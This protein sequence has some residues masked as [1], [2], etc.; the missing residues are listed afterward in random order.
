M[1]Y[2][3]HKNN[4]TPAYKE[5][6]KKKFKI[7]ALQRLQNFP[8]NTTEKLLDT[9]LKENYK[10]S[11]LETC[12]LI[13]LKCRLDESKDTFII[14]LTDKNLDKLARI[15]TFGT[16]HLSGSRLIPFIFGKIK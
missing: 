6:F 11:L 14:T 10:T 15:I 1:I 9:Y 8:I 3:V 7:N 16:G 4:Y 2:T 12:Y 13:I 5:F